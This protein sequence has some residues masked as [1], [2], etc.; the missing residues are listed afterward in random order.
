MALTLQCLSRAACR[1]QVAASPR[2][3]GVVTPK[4]P[5]L[6]PCVGG[7]AFFSP[8]STAA[9]S[10]SPSEGIWQRAAI[11]GRSPFLC[12]ARSVAVAQQE[13][14]ETS[15]LCAEAA[16]QHF[17]ARGSHSRQS[18]VFVDGPMPILLGRQGS[19][20]SKTDVPSAEALPVLLGR[21]KAPPAP[22]PAKV[23][24]GESEF[25]PIRAAHTARDAFLARQ[26]RI[27][28]RGITKQV[29]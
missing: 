9:F 4:T 22:E 26:K 21:V 8:L 27:D 1:Q 28:G 2:V 25:D 10:P 18:A 7:P 11:G 20:R 29:P 3:L 19:K 23:C 24:A 16:R 12:Q 15:R 14:V 17:L 5:A 6:S 13:A